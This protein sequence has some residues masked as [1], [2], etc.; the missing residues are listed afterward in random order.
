M[1]FVLIRNKDVPMFIFYRVKHLM[2]IVASHE[3]LVP[4]T[5]ASSFQILLQSHLKM[6]L[7][8]LGVFFWFVLL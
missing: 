6:E 3:V 8:T 2:H 4:H 5:F 1:E 7:Q